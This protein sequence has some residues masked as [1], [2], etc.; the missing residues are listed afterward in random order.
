MPPSSTEERS[1]VDMHWWVLC[2]Y[3]NQASRNVSEK[4]WKIPA[5]SPSGLSFLWGSWE[6][7]GW[8][9]SERFHPAVISQAEEWTMQ[10]WQTVAQGIVSWRSPLREIR[11][12]TRRALPTQLIQPLKAWVPRSIQLT[13]DKGARQRKDKLACFYLIMVLVCLDTETWKGKFKWN[14]RTER[15]DIN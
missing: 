10:R 15:L 1:R 9:D 5:L 4:F 11:Q 12:Q 14:T 7:S 8:K 6:I 3:R 13:A 2:S